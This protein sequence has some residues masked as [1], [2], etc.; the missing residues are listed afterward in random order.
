LDT[1]I[2]HHRYQN[3]ETGRPAYD[4]ALLLKIVLLAYSRGITSSRKIEQLCRENVIFMALS[5]NSQPHFTTIA[6]FISRSSEEISQL[7]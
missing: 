2:F 6:D 1:S 4:P 5:A 7:F 3:D